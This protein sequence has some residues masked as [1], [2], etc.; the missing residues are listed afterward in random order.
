MDFTIKKPN[1]ILAALLVVFAFTLIILLPLFTYFQPISTTPSLNQ[2]PQSMR[3][4][5]ELFTLIIQILFVAIGL[6]ILIPV[7]W[8]KLVNNYTKKQILHQIKLRREA[9]DIAILWGILT[10]ILMFITLFIIGIILTTLGYNLEQSGNI[11][12]LKNLFSIPSLFI[13]VTIQPIGEEI[14][15]RGFLLEKLKTT[16]GTLPAILISSILFGIAHL[17]AQNIYPAIIT[18]ILGILLAY[19]VIKTKHL[20]TAISAHIFYNIISVSL[21]LIGQSFI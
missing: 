10:M 13:I 18:A 8:Y 11:Q 17:S 20:I 5:V 1:H 6:F 3:F 2:L 19:M 7:I 21:Y 12:D 4:A 14:F 9:A 15:F 16:T